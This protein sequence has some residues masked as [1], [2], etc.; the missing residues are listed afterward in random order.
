MKKFFKLVL[1]LVLVVVPATILS[2]CHRSAVQKNTVRIGLVGSDDEKI[3]HPIAKRLAKQGVH[4]KIV[5]FSDYTQPNQALQHHE[6]DVNS[7]QTYQFLDNWNHAHH[8]HFVSD[9]RTTIQ[10]LGLYSK[11]VKNLKDLKKGSTIT[12]PN[13]SSNEAR[14]LNLLKSAGLIKLKKAALPSKADVYDNKKHLHLKPVNAAQTPRTLKDADAAIINANFAVDANL[15]PKKAIYTEKMNRKIIPYINVIASTKSE[16]KRK[17]V[18]KV[19]RTYQSSANAKELKKFFHGSEV[20]AW[21][22]NF[23]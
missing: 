21:K 1:A 19:V 20:P 18:R 22:I 6:T 3:W 12:L 2:G 4:L 17:A 8:T 13:D 16:K 15:K 9:G 5:D 23:K 10:P 11:N 14:G 7:F